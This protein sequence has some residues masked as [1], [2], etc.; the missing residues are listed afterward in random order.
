M[1]KTVISIL[2][3]PKAG[4]EEAVGRTFNALAL[5]LELKEKGQPFEVIY[6]GAGS[7]WPAELAKTDHPLN[8]LYEAVKDNIAGVSGGCADLFGATESVERDTGHKLIRDVAIPG[9]GGVIDMAKH[10][11]NGD[12]FITF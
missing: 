11:I 9:T 6:Q 5:A 7:R 4:G 3:D 8:A 2:S 1:N 10:V 12:R